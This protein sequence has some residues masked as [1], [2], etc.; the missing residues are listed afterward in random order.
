MRKVTFGG[1]PS[2]D[3]YFAR[4]DDAV[5]WLMWSKE[6][7]TIMNDYWRTVDTI[8]IGRKTYEAGLKMTKGKGHPYSGMKAY[9]FSRTLKPRKQGELEI[10]A[11]D[12]VQFVKRLKKADGKDICVMGG[13][14]LARSLFEADLIDEIGFNL[15][16]VLLGSGIPLF[17]EM[18]RQIDLELLECKPFQNGCVYVSYRVKRSKP[19]RAR[20]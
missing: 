10:V 2:L 1:A 18:K 19:K 5:D 6:A 13:G 9:V 14:D 8:V 20:K 7:A 3:G 17:H 12:A 16:P 11:G 4:K 15:H